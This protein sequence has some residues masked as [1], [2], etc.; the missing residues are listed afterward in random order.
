MLHTGRRLIVASA[1]AFLFGC[2]SSTAPSVAPSPMAGGSSPG[3]ADKGA[4]A[5]KSVAELIKG[6]R[7]YDGLFTIYQDTATGT[8]QIGVRRDQ[9]G[10]EFIYNAVVDEGVLPA[11]AFRGQYGPNY[12]FQ[13][14]RRFNK[15]EFVIRNTSFYFDPGSPLRR[16]ADAN[17]SPSVIA[18]I[19]IAGEDTATGEMIIKSDDLFLTE[20]FRQVKPTPD[21][22][23]RPGTTFQLGTLSKSKTR[24]TG[25]RSYPLNS[26]VLVEYVYEN[27]APVVRGDADVTDARNV[28]VRV[29]HSLIQM[30][31]DGYELRFDD[32]RVGFF[33]ESVTDLTSA[34]VTP[35]RDLI[36]RWDLRKKDP[37]AALSEPIHPIVWWIENTT[38]VELRP[39]IKEGVL[40]WNEAFEQ[41]GFKN[42]MV[43][44]EQPDTATW[45]AGD[46]RYNVLRWTSSPNP[47]FGGYGPNVTNPRTGQVLGADIML[48]Y[49]YVTNRI[50]AAD[51]FEWAG[52]Q[53]LE[54]VLPGI[55]EAAFCS[56]G[57]FMQ[58]QALFG[59]AALRLLG[60]SDAEVSSFVNDAVISL[61]LHEVG[62]T[63]GL[64]HNMK[65]TQAY[66][67]AELQDPEFVRT[68]GVSG[69]VMDYHAVNV[70]PPGGRRTQ[71]VDTHPGVYDRW[72]IEY[73]YRPS[74]PDPGAEQA[75]VRA[76][77][78]RSTEPALA[79]GNDADDMRSPG[80]GINPRV[81]IGDMSSDAIAFAE[82]RMTLADSLMKTILPRYTRRDSSYA[83]LLTAYF[84]T[85]GQ[86]A[87]QA[88][89]VARYIGGVEVDR[90][91][92][93]QP[94]ATQPLTPV[95]LAEQ[96]RA[97]RLLRDRVFAPG[98][99][100]ASP[101]LLA[102]LQPQRR[103]FGFFGTTEDPKIHARVLAAQRSVLDHLLHPMTLTRM[104]DSRAYGG[105]YSVA[106]MVGD[107]TDAIFAADARGDV[108]T[109]RQNLQ[110]EYVNRLAAMITGESRLRY[111]YVARSAAVANLRSIQAQVARPAGNAE[112]RAHRAHLKLVADRALAVPG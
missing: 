30:P 13:V 24:I 72:A 38:P 91:F 29:L 27:P 73:G 78:S 67:P 64:T 36:N 54:P 65:A 26:D 21:P 68:H 45:D 89:V 96:K 48:E 86:I 99:F 105:G 17:I 66:S 95:P 33:T 112:T 75:R 55:Q 8:T 76:V 4:T 46:L 103:G 74:L 60:A 77:V 63:L 97:M 19:E 87:G 98:A 18:S 43:V 23:A 3:Q 5:K 102:H 57:Q 49:I 34:S 50:R 14:N 80:G 85:S 40:R 90:A 62:H 69:S 61:V 82:G 104:T 1:A 101:E 28:S 111:D 41:A 109:F 20:A 56:F 25:I 108:N 9:L 83:S 70:P 10:K 59:A 107:L 93:G 6:S 53:Q 84:I 58:E 32:P 37:S 12:V 44:Y 42:A 52:Q 92:A 31:A 22:N 71:S 81:M 88:G 47:P 15:I 51:L 94:G 11:G 79:Y 100:G 106:A 39:A 2:G 16:A 35:Y 110:V 7:K